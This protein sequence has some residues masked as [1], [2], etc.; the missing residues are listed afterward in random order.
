[1]TVAWGSA[2][3]VTSPNERMELSNAPILRP[4]VAYLRVSTQKQ[5]RSGLGLDA[6]RDTISRFAENEGFNIVEWFEEVETAKGID[7]LDRR[8][9]LAGAL[10]RAR[11]LKG[12]IVVSKLDRLSRD[13]AFIASL[14]AQRVPFVVTELGVDADPFLLHV[15]AALAE[16]ERSMIAARTRVALQAKRSA[17]YRLGNPTNLAEASRLGAAEQARAAADFAR[18]LS[19]LIESLR[20]TGIT[21]QRG[22]ADALNQRGVR[23]PRGAAW[24]AVTI[25]RVL[26]RL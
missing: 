3:A 19:P 18:S 5:G 11:K 9:M 22:L 20:A 16:K 17:G 7:A 6:Q 25:G 10:A 12:P 21:S 13:V 15:Y 1:M 14:M 4:A 2:V 26:R 24:S 8:P 23:T